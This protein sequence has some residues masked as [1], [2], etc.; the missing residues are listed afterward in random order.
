[1]DDHELLERWVRE[2]D[3]GAFGEVVGRYV[4]MVYAAALRQTGNRTLAEDVAQGVFAL[5]AERAGSLK[6]GTVLA[7]WLY[8]ATRYVSANALKLER[9]RAHHERRAAA[10]HQEHDDSGTANWEAVS[11]ELDAAMAELGEGDREVLLLRYFQ[12]QSLADVGRALRISEDAAKKRASRAMERLRTVLGRR[13][14]AA[15]SAASLAVVIGAHAAEAAPVGLAGTVTAAATAGTLTGG[16]AAL[17]KGVV[18]AMAWTKTK[19][20]VAGCV[21][22]AVLLGGGVVAV[23]ALGDRKD[24][25]GPAVQRPV[26]EVQTMNAAQVIEANSPLG[27][28]ETLQD[29]FERGDE[30][31]I[32]AACTPPPEADAARMQTFLNLDLAFTRMLRLTQARFGPQARNLA[33]NQVTTGEVLDGLLRHATPAHVTIKGDR[34]TFVPPVDADAMPPGWSKPTLYFVREDGQWKVDLQASFV[35]EVELELAD[36][37][38]N[39]TVDKEK[40]MEAILTGMTALFTRIADE[41]EAGRMASLAEAHRTM[42]TG[43]QELVWD[44]RHFSTGMRPRGPQ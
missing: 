18:T 39:R 9:R 35:F 10:M 30:A 24:A 4:N 13:G 8:R 33:A 16:G 2:G 36:A 15:A 25:A 22:L 21:V 1:M 19:A 26:Q 34:A 7:G 12:G 27:V 29:A 23:R 31:A 6:R 41:T 38:A 11:G 44:V 28:L 42:G 5:L 43:M 32:K 14:V 20:V 37:E 40:R 17:V 3:S